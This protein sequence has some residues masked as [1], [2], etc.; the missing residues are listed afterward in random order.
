[1]ETEVKQLY[2]RSSRDEGYFIVGSQKDA[3]EDAHLERHMNP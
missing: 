1:M 3:L 2:K